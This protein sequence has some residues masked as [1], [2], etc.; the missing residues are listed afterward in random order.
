[1]ISI[2]LLLVMTQLAEPYEKP[3]QY[4]EWWQEVAQCSGYEVTEAELDSIDFWH[5]N[6]PSFIAKGIPGFTGYAYVKLNEIYVIRALKNDKEV[7]KHEMLHF[8]LWWRKEGYEG[9]HPEDTNCDMGL[10]LSLWIR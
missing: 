8:I 3:D 10:D 9:G 6:A 4:Y 2:A 1:V 7:I 5:V